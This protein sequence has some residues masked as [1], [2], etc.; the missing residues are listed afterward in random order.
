[1][2]GFTARRVRRTVPVLAQSL[3]LGL[4][5]TL[6]GALSAQEA[7]PPLPSFA[8]L[9][10]AGARI[11]EIRVLSNNIFDTDDPKE[12]KLLFRWANAL[13]IRTRPG[14]IERA[15]LFK[16]GDP[17]SVR[18]I[19]ETERVLRSNQYLYDVQFRPVAYH[20]GVVDIEVATRDT[21][22]LDPGVSAGRSGGV[23]SGGIHLNEY[24]LL[25]TGTAVSIGRSKNVDRSSNEFKFTN[26]HA[27]GTWTTLGYTHVLT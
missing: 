13:H 1:M 27:F 9:E 15:L 3:A 19:D 24:N 8:E 16:T 26:S 22:S 4:A 25:G 7:M 11:G 23:N 14:V 6:S 10:A 21:W 2:N 18:L 5:W 12:D 17:L 20:D